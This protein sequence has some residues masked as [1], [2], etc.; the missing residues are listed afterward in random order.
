MDTT[1]PPGNPP[2]A[3]WRWLTA[4]AC[5]LAVAAAAVTIDHVAWPADVA[6]IVRW[7]GRFHPVLLHF[8]IALIVLALAFEVTRLPGLR[9]ILPRPDPQTVTVV[10]GWG[11]VAATFALV[12][13]W[14]LGQSGGYDR[15]LL[16]RHLWTGAATTVGAN[17]ALVVRLAAGDP[18]R[19]LPRTMASLVLAGTGVALAVAGHY[20]ASLT[21]GDGYLTDDAPPVLRQWLGLPA[22]TGPSPAQVKPFEQRVLWA[23]VAAPVLTEYCVS[24]HRQG[25]AKGGLRLDDAAAMMAGGESGPAIHAGDAAASLLVRRMRLG[26][27]QDGHMPPTGKPQPS[28]D[29]LAVVE[30]WINQGAPVD[31]TIADLDVPAEVRVLL[32]SLVSPAQREHLAAQAR[33]EAAALEQSLA[34]LQRDLPGRL[35]F[36]VPGKPELG[37]AA[38]SNA[39]AVEDGHLAAMAPVSA[40]L[41]SMDLQQTKITDAGVAT[42]KGFTGLRRL[43]LQNTAITDAALQSLAALSALEELNLYGTSITDAGLRHLASSK[44]LR[45]INLWQTRVTPAG[46]ANLRDA[47]PGL[48]I[49]LG[50]DALP[51]DPPP[52]TTTPAT[53]EPPKPS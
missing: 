41:V 13:G 7:A 8:P 11:A 43:H 1:H 20:G 19:W 34:A 4:A 37:Y 47:I 9:W 42:L 53:P 3:R 21:H 14:L 50:L 17:L 51:A 27:E 18:P 23:D 35:S 31:Q 38:G 24:C 2:L 15:D 12:C 39:S 16:E 28:P 46:V 52:R 36:V 26:L 48:T 33:D 29:E 44:T 22:R 25:K 45:K 6:A 32:E 40:R 49:N 5:G 10:L 30:W